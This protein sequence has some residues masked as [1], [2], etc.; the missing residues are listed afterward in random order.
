M[1]HFEIYKQRKHQKSTESMY[2]QLYKTERSFSTVY[3]NSLNLR[4]VQILFPGSNIVYSLLT[5]THF[6]IMIYEFLIVLL[7]S[8][9]GTADVSGAAGPG[10]DI[11]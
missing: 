11:F 3:L 2:R 1:C 9:E 10:K 8:V 5:N 7:Q 4:T 6:L